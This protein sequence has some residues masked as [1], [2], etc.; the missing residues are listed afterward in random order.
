MNVH[1]KRLN[2]V[3]VSRIGYLD[4]GAY[5]K[6]LTLIKKHLTLIK[7][8]LRVVYLFDQLFQ[9]LV[10]SALS[11]PTDWILYKNYIYLFF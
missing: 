10:Y 5:T 1:F 4:A 11:G 8:H 2:I 7:K 6:P 3:S 9:I